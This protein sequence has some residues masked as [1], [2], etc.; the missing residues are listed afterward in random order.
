MAE[1]GALREWVFNYIDR[2]FLQMQD[3]FNSA[4]TV[5]FINNY[6]EIRRGKERL[7]LF[8]DCLTI[9]YIPAVVSEIY[10]IR[11]ICE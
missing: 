9:S 7:K 1:G 10:G 5:K 2:D 11:L 4:E 8:Q 3:I 6:M